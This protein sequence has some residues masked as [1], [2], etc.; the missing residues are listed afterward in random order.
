MIKVYD[1]E[2]TECP[3]CGSL[4]INA[5]PDKV[6][7]GGGNFAGDCIAAWCN[8]CEEEWTEPPLE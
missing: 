3:N 6:F 4:N 7:D 2:Q 8:D 1:D 5:E